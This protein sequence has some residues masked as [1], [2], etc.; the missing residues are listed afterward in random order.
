M[1]EVGLVTMFEIL[2]EY[3][4]LDDNLSKGKVLAP[5]IR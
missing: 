4:S 1:F 3:F 5:L 2:I